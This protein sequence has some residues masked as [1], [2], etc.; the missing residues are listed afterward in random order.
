M[1]NIERL[2]EKAKQL[3]KDGNGKGLCFV[4]QAGGGQWEA[5]ATIY[6]RGQYETETATH[7]SREAAILWGR[8]KIG[9]NGQMLI[10]DVAQ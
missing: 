2:L 4:S 7:D 5:A 1:K 9:D 10:D 3:H 6:R 8:S